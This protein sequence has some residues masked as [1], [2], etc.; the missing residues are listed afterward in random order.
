MGHIGA[1]RFAWPALRA[2]RNHGTLRSVNAR[3]GVATTR[4]LRHGT[5]SAAWW[6]HLAQHLGRVAVEALHA[7]A[8]Y[9]RNL[10]LRNAEHFAGL[11]RAALLA[12]GWI[13]VLWHCAAGAAVFEGLAVAGD[14]AFGLRRGAARAPAA[15]RGPARSCAA[16]RRGARS[17]TRRGA[18]SA[19]RRGAR[20]ATRRGARSATPAAARAV[21]RRVPATSDHAREGNREDAHRS[22]NQAH[23]QRIAHLVAGRSSVA[24]VRAT[25]PRRPVACPQVRPGAGA[26]ARPEARSVPAVAVGRIQHAVRL[27][28][29]RM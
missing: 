18:R 23:H 13:R 29:R 24:V 6:Q 12:D 11:V 14:R 28:R 27:E 20:S 22:L 17:A 5:S 2:V 19:A 26:A 3:P 21:A 25:E 8:R 1:A 16:A 15:A 10:R 4:D 9:A 7:A